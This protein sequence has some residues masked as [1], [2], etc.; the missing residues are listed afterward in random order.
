M[1]PAPL[2]EILPDKGIVYGE[3]KEL[4]PILCRPKLLPI[5]SYS[6]ERLER[7]EEKTLKEAKQRRDAEKVERGVAA[8]NTAPTAQQRLQQ[9]AET[10]DSPKPSSPPPCNDAE[11][12]KESESSGDS[13]L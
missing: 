11:A 1:D 2:T 7:L 12:P 10:R 13:D 9:P 8:W 6:L 4:Q 3:L 5:K